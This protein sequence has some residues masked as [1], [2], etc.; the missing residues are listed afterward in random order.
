MRI[1]WKNCTALLVD[2]LHWYKTNL[3]RGQTSQ[4][5]D[6]SESWHSPQI[7]PSSAPNKEETKCF[8]FVFSN[9]CLYVY[10]CLIE[11]AREDNCCTARTSGLKKGTRKGWEEQYSVQNGI[12]RKKEEEK[13]SWEYKRETV[14]KKKK[15]QI[16]NDESIHKSG[17]IIQAGRCYS[18]RS[19]SDIFSF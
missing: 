3:H 18:S 10:T 1:Q 13:E 11:K 2:H 12:W 6:L 8:V 15:L 16:C 4:S 17:K 5:P 14:R 9:T 19:G 7:S